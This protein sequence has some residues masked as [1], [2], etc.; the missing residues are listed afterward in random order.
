M[1]QRIITGFIG[2]IFFFLFIYI[3]QLP[4]ALFLLALA[5]I[6]Y[7]EFVRMAGFRR[8]D[9]LSWTGYG[10]IILWFAIGIGWIPREFAL[11][12]EQ[13]AWFSV[14]ILLAVT[15]LSRNK[16]NFVHI[17]TL[18]VAAFYIA[19]G[20]YYIL[21]T[22]RMDDG[23]LWTFFVLLCTWGSD[24][25][26]YFTG[27]QF[28]KRKLWPLISPKKTVEGSIGGILWSV[29]IALLFAFLYPEL[30]SFSKA[31]LLAI[32]IALVGQLGDL[33]ESAYKRYYN[34]KDSGSLLPGHGG[35]L[36]RVDSWIVVFP[37]LHLSHF[38]S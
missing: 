4:Y 3:G 7:D 10:L 31:I 25:G 8:R 33:I 1:K 6:G 23:L 17:A 15:V 2:A 29:A 37:F 18:W 26:A 30:V 21:E 5:L 11:N 19:V 13:I 12:F 24:T 38:L 28:G 34:I 35:V 20:F 36:D 32:T 16:F 22:R 27:R 14:F 9:S